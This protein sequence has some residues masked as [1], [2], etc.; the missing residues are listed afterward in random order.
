MDFSI[1]IYYFN[2]MLDEAWDKNFALNVGTRQKG[3]PEKVIL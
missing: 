2:P 3:K 1:D